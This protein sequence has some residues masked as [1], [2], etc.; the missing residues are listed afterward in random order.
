MIKA[1]IGRELTIAALKRGDKVIATARPRS[2]EA[3]K[4]LKLFGAEVT[5]HIDVLRKIT[6]EA[7]AIYTYNHVNVVMSSAG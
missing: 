5:A 2:F 7:S 3:I 1:R 6:A 4:D